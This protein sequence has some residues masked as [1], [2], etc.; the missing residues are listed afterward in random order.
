MIRLITGF[1]THRLRRRRARIDRLGVI[2]M[3][4]CSRLAEGLVGPVAERFGPT[5]HRAWD[6]NLVIV[7]G[8]LAVMAAL[9][10]VTG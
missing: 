4:N 10:N 5:D 8:S 9:G 2:G 7:A 1:D 3:A 6:D